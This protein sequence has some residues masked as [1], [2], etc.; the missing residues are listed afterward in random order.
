MEGYTQPFLTVPQEAAVIVGASFVASLLHQ[1]IRQLS[2]LSFLTAVPGDRSQIVVISDKRAMFFY[3]IF[4]TKWFGSLRTVGAAW[5]HYASL[6]GLYVLSKA[7]LDKYLGNTAS[8]FAA[9]AVAGLAQSLIRHPYDVLRATAEHPSA[10]KKFSGPFDVLWTSV[11]KKP[12]ALLELYRGGGLAAATT[13]AQFSILFGCYN[14]IKEDRVARGLHHLFLGIHVI[15]CATT[16]IAYPFLNLRQLTHISNLHINGA[17]KMR[18]ADGSLVTPKV[19]M[20][21]MFWEMKKKHGI[22]KVYDGYF[23]NRPFLAIAPLSL[24]I[25]LYDLGCRRYTEM[26]HPSRTRQHADPSQY[27]MRPRIPQYVLDSR[28]AAASR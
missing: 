13:C 14:Y 24:A 4:T 20:S 3:N 19:T 9:G 15:A 7:S 27:L 1:P 6:I 11:R 23:R 26:I 25:T 5:C 28:A 16:L 18:T 17:M 21:H 22:T 8:G 12:S 10:P 2:T